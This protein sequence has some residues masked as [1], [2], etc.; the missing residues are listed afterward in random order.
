M[1]T[2]EFS[3]NFVFFEFELANCAIFY[4]FK[5]CSIEFNCWNDLFT[6]NYLLPQFVFSKI[7]F[8]HGLPALEVPVVA[9]KSYYQDSGIF[10]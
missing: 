10:G 2:C 3:K 9:H 4:I 6:F 8:Q 1:S 7:H 5:F